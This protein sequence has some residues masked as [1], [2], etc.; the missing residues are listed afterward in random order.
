MSRS[1]LAALLSLVLLSRGGNW[2][3]LSAAMP[4]WSCRPRSISASSSARGGATP[5]LSGIRPRRMPDEEPHHLGRGVRALGIGV[6]ADR[7]ATEPGM[8]RAL[9]KPVLGDDGA[10]RRAVHGAGVRPGAVV[11]T[12]VGDRWDRAGLRG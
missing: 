6:T 8:S 2:I 10:V 7:V 12:V 11:A 3:S 9:D 5:A 1:C 4:A